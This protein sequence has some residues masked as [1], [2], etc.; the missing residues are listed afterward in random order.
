MISP[1]GELANDKVKCEIGMSQPGPIAKELYNE[2][3][4]VQRGLLPD[5]FNW[6][7]KLV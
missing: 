2:I 6:L 5:R 4:G 7:R 3:S 1:I